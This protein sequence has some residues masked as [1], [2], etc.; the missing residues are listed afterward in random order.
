MPNSIPLPFKTCAQHIIDVLNQL[1]IPFVFGVPGGAIE[2]L[3]NAMSLSQKQGQLKPIVARH[4]AGALFMA[5]GFYKEAGTLPVCC[6]TSGPGA[7]NMLTGVA[8]AFENSI[9]LLVITGQPAISLWGKN[10]LQ[11]SSCTGV[12]LLSMFKTCTAYNS[13]VS[14]PDQLGT[15]LAQALNIAL[16]YKKPVHLSIPVDIQRATFKNN[17]SLKN[18]IK[19]VNHLELKELEIIRRE[20][21]LS[22][23]PLFLIGSEC[24]YIPSVNELISKCKIPFIVTPDAL[25]FI[26]R[27]SALYKGVYGFAG[28]QEA[29]DLVMNSDV[30]MALGVDISE[31]TT[32]AWDSVNLLC[33]KTTFINGSLSTSPYVYAAHKDYRTDLAEVLKYLGNELNVE[34]Q[35]RSE[36][37]SVESKVVAVKQMETAAIKPQLLMRT[38]FKKMPTDSK[39]YADPGN[40]TVWLIHEYEGYVETVMRFASMGWSIG[41]AVG[42]KLGGASNVA[43][44]SGDGSYLMSGQEITV[45]LQH[46]LPVVYIVLNDAALGMVKHGQR[47]AEAEQTSFELPLAN[48]AELAK[49]LG[50][51]GVRLTTYAE[52]EALDMAHL[53]SLNVPTLIDVLIDPEEVPPMGLRIKTLNKK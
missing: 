16:T 43:C 35:L 37:L 49:S 33:N 12:D 20:L 2:P 1:S 7:T 27:S 47:L 38:L 48:Y 15:K 44:I 9:P 5:D 39:I 32:N 13:L 14:H 18:V 46:N 8:S 3:Y 51:N 10:S 29:T 25:G 23:A 41:A 4:E 24:R 50:C 6:A 40:S 30:V 22:E 28:H 19:G 26:N 45:A 11:E 31:W 53:F 42:A 36:R 21:E 52:L 34:T 17:L